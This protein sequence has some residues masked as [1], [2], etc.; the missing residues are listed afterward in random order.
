MGG[1]REV[2]SL[3]CNYHMKR[4]VAYLQRLHTVNHNIFA[5]LLFSEFARIAPY[6]FSDQVI[7]KSTAQ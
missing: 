3:E 7:R 1:A 5:S 4:V 2:F 6:K